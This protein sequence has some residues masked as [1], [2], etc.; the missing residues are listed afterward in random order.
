EQW[1][2]RQHST[3]TASPQATAYTMTGWLRS[4]H[5]AIS[6]GGSDHA[7]TSATVRQGA[8]ARSCGRQFATR[9]NGGKCATSTTAT[10]SS[11]NGTA[12]KLFC[13]N[14]AAAMEITARPQMPTP[15]GARTDRLPRTTAN[16]PYSSGTTTMR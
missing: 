13:W 12:S 16:G 7:S 4:S 3:S 10:G 6:A 1:Q 11:S 14:L 8:K 9:A 2:T 15:T 5:Q